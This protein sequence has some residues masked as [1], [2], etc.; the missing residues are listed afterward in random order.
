M[1]SKNKWLSKDGKYYDDYLEKKSADYAWET[2][3]K[4]QQQQNA[5]LAE[6]NRLLQEENDRKEKL[7]QE[8][9]AFEREKEQNRYEEML[10]QQQHDKEMRILGL[11]DSIGLN[12]QYYDNFIK[13]LASNNEK[14]LEDIIYDRDSIKDKIEEIDDILTDPVNN[15]NEKLT[16]W[17]KGTREEYSQYM[18]EC[19]NTDKKA[20]K[21]RLKYEKFIN[22]PWD[23]TEKDVQCFKLEKN[24]ETYIKRQKDY[25][26]YEKMSKILLF[27][28]IISFILVLLFAVLDSIYNTDIYESNDIFMNLALFLM[29]PAFGVPIIAGIRAKNDTKNVYITQMKGIIQKEI[30]NIPVKVLD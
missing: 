16:S 5:L 1:S 2:Q 25:Q 29:I 27:T 24:R 8:R 12:K 11:F 26:N 6:Q 21:L 10:E 15:M 28:C 14:D 20:E 3:R 7:E 30:N 9:L 4:E 19:Y 22:T 17:H 23:L 18:K 13:Y